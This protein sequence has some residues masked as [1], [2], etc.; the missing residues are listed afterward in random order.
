MQDASHHQDYTTFL[1]GNPSKTFILPLLIWVILGKSKVLPPQKKIQE[2]P[3]GFLKKTRGPVFS[4][5]LDI[6]KIKQLERNPTEFNVR[7]VEDPNEREAI[8][9]FNPFE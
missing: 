3:F 6:P 5:D 9:Q 1:V 4:R 2:L 8:L 7:Y